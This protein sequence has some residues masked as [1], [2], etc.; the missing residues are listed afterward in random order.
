[1]MFPF[2]SQLARRALTALFL[3]GLGCGIAPAR[4]QAPV[5]L[6]VAAPL[7]TPASTAPAPASAD[8][9][10]RLGAQPLTLPLKL[11]DGHLVLGVTLFNTSGADDGVS[12]EL[13]LDYPDLLT[14]D[15]DQHG[16]LGLASGAKGEGEMV[17]VKFSNGST[18]LIPGKD[19]TA[20]RSAARGNLHNQ[21]TA[22]FANQLDDRKLKGVLGLAFLKSYQA[23]LNGASKQL[24]LSPL[25]SSSGGR[26]DF[27]AAFELKDGQ[28]TLPLT[29]PLAPGLR[30]ILGSSNYD[31]LIDPTLA[32]KLGK[33]AGDL[34]PLWFASLDLA[35]FL[36]FRPKAWT[37]KPPAEGA[38]LPLLLTGVNLL[39][40]FKLDFDWNNSRVR[41]V[42]E[43]DLPPM[44][45]ADRAFFLAEAAN[46]AEAYQAFL[47]KHLTHRLAADAATR[48]MNFRLEEWGVADESVMQALQ[49]VLDTALPE[50]RLD[51][52]M[53]YVN[54]IATTPGKT[55]LS[56]QMGLLA[57]KQ[58]RGAVTIQHVYRLHR[59]LGELYLEQ[60]NLPEA[61]SHLMSA[62][63]VPL[64]R[65]DR[66]RAFQAFRIA[67]N[68]GRVYDR[69]NRYVRA[70]SRYKA[71]L[72]V[73]GAPI[74]ATE[75]QEIADAIDRLRKQI[76]AD[77]LAM[78]D[79]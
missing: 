60:D 15:G 35:K 65:S 24:T 59:I 10:Q 55:A 50:R 53:S 68:L 22:A 16:W 26:S 72:A 69:Q 77:D 21:I 67:L 46:T 57:L 29:S 37:T 45:A 48:L 42:Q 5:P 14:L 51:S 70:Y 32:K 3:S 38:D 75:K 4:A 2:S 40:S 12:L 1:M 9:G 33:P 8:A 18:V 63:F 58:A 11:V 30:M 62:S 23:S 41:F 28:M 20:E 73:A 44:P 78:L 49:W 34:E 13:A 31:T 19:I 74:T 61:W 71:A 64:N 52:C 25:G 39:E 54:R 47:T 79:S 56:I 17:R 66:D 36:V 6:R 76:P 7:P 43:K 27:S